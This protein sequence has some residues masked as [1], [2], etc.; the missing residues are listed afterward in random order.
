MAA[1]VMTEEKWY[2]LFIV[3]FWGFMLV[4]IGW[5]IVEKVTQ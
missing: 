3:L 1:A 2:G 5:S 4:M